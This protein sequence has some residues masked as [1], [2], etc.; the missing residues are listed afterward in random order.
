[1]KYFSST[2]IILTFFHLSLS[3]SP[4]LSAQVNVRVLFAQKKKEAKVVGEAMARAVSAE[5]VQVIGHTYLLYKAG[6]PPKIDL[7]KLVGPAEG[8]GASK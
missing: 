6:T 8:G 5:L 4:P 1:M 3:L 2:I 7:D